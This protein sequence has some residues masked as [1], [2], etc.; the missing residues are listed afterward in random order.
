MKKILATTLFGALLLS[1]PIAS[2]Q[3]PEQPNIDE[4]IAKQIEEFERLYHIDEVQVFFVDSVLQTNFP[5]MM[6]EFENAKKGGAANAETFQLISDVWMDRTDKALEKIFTPQ[7]WAKYM[8]SAYGKE[9][10]KRDKR[11]SDRS[12][13]Q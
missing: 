10:K 12:L 1:A 5:G 2:A 4:I 6:A 11:L 3:E 13:P 7:Q 9:K 8:K